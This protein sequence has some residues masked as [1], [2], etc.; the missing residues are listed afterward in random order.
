MS[1]TFIGF[2]AVGVAV[3]CGAA[4]RLQRREQ[5][6]VVPWAAADRHFLDRGM[7]Y[8]VAGRFSALSQQYP[9]CA[10]LLHH[11]VE[12]LLKGSLCRTHSKVQLR[13]MG[14]N[15]PRAWRAFEA[16]HPD[17]RLAQFNATIKALNKFEQIRYPDGVL[18]KGMSGTFDLF[19]E[20][21]SELQSSVGYAPPQ[22]S[23]NLE[24]VDHLV[25]LVFEV[26]K[27][28][29]RFFVNSM[30]APAREILNDRNRHPFPAA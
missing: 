16:S 30:S 19:H 8:Y 14:H 26:A 4:L 15:L 22:Y 18:E 2:L 28:N 12:M 1:R 17:P 27:F 13:A 24:D 20:H 9:I 10:N 25:I 7:Q 11:S 23:L 6:S 21:K 29:S 3:L 5:G